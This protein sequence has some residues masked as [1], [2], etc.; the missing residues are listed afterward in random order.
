M[1]IDLDDVL[2]SE[3]AVAAWQELARRVVEAMLVADIVIDTQS[4]PDERTRV[5]TDGSLTIYVVVPGLGEVSM[6]ILPEQWAR[7]Q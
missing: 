7:K 4:I 5:E 2:L 1:E 3:V 6:T